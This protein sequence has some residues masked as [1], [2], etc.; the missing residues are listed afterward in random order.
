ML[1]TI[2]QAVWPNGDMCDPEDVDA[3]MLSLSLSDDYSVKEVAVSPD[4]IAE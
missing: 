1:F 4:E 3:Y 2:K